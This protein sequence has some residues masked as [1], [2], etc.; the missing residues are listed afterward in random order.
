MKYLAVSCI[1]LFISFSTVFAQEKDTLKNVSPFIN[2]QGD[3]QFSSPELKLQN[4]FENNDILPGDVDHNSV[5]LWT[6]YA[7]SKP[8]Y[9][10]YLPG[11]AEPHMLANYHDMYVENNKFSM[12]KTVLG[13]AQVG[14]VGY[15][16]VKS[17]QKHGFI[18]NK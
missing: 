2:L 7:I 10:T 13:M 12:V 14:A 18:K 8:G 1:L 4:P 11:A 6:S 5:W 17:I 3:M 16:A 15:L 9:G